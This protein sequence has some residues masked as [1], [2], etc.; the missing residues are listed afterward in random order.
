LHI[1]GGNVTIKN[2]TISDNDVGIE[3]GRE[4]GGAGNYNVTIENN[5]ITRNTKGI[6]LTHLRSGLPLGALIVQNYNFVNNKEANFYLNVAHS[7]D[8]P[9][10]WWG[11]SD[12][13]AISQT[14]HDI[15]DDFNHGTVNFM[16]FLTQPNPD[17]PQESTQ[18]IPMATQEATAPISKSPDSAVTNQNQTSPPLINPQQ[19][20]V[21]DSFVE[22]DTIVLIVGVVAVSV[23]VLS[24]LAYKLRK[25]V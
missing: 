5:L 13:A 12:I 10:N 4:D 6:S 15:N 17:A 20:G 8:T 11:T 1:P 18:P 16:P 14:I 22:V 9:N 19:S 21:E 7:V 3:F 24:T 25:R 2:N 23:F